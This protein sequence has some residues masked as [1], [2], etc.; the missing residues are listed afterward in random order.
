MGDW[1]DRTTMRKGHKRAS[2]ALLVATA[3]SMVL[4]LPAQ[5]D[6]APRDRPTGLAFNQAHVLSWG[7]PPPEDA[8]IITGYRLTADDGT[9]PE[10]TAELPADATQYQIEL[11]GSRR[12]QVVLIAES[13]AGDSPPTVT[14]ACVCQAPTAP[15]DFQFGTLANGHFGVSWAPPA[16]WGGPDH[17]Y[18]VSFVG[19][20]GYPYL[21]VQSGDRDWID[22][23]DQVAQGHSLRV[24]AINAALSGTPVVVDAEVPLPPRLPGPI[25]I[26]QATESPFGYSPSWVVTRAA[27]R[28][29][30]CDP[31]HPLHGG[32]SACDHHPAPPDPG[33][34]LVPLRAECAAA[35]RSSRARRLGREHSRSRTEHV[36]GRHV[37]PRTRPVPAGLCH[38]DR[39]GVMVGPSP[40]RPSAFGH[41]LAA[42]PP[43]W[44]GRGG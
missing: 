23:S 36:A 15:T 37:R 4:A 14:W 31:A 21:D 40:G 17:R 16:D 10:F 39:A 25:T 26:V 22:L 29:R 7:A 1:S 38:A 24:V 8:A 32:R 43:R 34:S 12:Y 41:D 33:R 2:I 3:A 28:R 5:A 42:D 18:D 27:F 19:E 13:A 30:G 6:A 20:T 9:D 44:T 35:E 11:P